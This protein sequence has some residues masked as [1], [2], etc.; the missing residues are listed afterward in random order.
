MHES[1]HQLH[2]S[3]RISKRQYFINKFSKEFLFSREA[4]IKSFLGNEEDELIN[5]ELLGQVTVEIFLFPLSSIILTAFNNWV[6]FRA[7]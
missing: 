7:K 1:K 5:E 3:L 4:L 6:V 2:I